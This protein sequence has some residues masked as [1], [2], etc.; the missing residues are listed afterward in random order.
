[1][2][3]PNSW[4]SLENR[5][6]R[7]QLQYSSGPS[8][9]SCHLASCIYAV[10]P[11]AGPIALIPD[12]GWGITHSLTIHT[13]S[14]EKLHHIERLRERVKL[15]DPPFRAVA[16]G[17][18]A[19]DLLTI[20]YNDGL[21]IRLPG[22]GDL[23]HVRS[24]RVF[25]RDSVYD[26]TVLHTGDVVIRTDSGTV[27]RVDAFEKLLTESFNIRPPERVAADILNSGISAIAPENSS[28]EVIETVLITE[29]RSV[30]VANSSGVHTIASTNVS[31]IAL[32]SNGKYV[33]A[34]ESSTGGIFVWDI[35]RQTEI[36][37]LN[38]VVELSILG[39]ENALSEE[40]FDARK[41]DSLSWVGS[42]AIAVLYKEH[43]VLVGPKR[44]IAV[45]HLGESEIT[46]GVILNNEKDGLRLISAQRIEF[47][48]MVP[49][50]ITSIFYQK[51]APSYKLFK[52]SGV[53]DGIEPIS[54]QALVRYRLLRELR[55]AGTLLEAA[56]SCVNAAYLELD[57]KVQKQLLRAAAY[58]QR[59][60]T[61]FADDKDSAMSANS[62]LPVM[63]KRRDARLR[64]DVGM[65]PTA[66]AILR[67]LNA[68]AS[69]LSGVPLT[70]TQFDSL[71]LPGLVARLSR[72]GKHTL[73]L[74]LASF[75]GISPYDVLAEWSKDV[76]RNHSNE[77]D[78]LIKYIIEDKFEA[79]SK[80][81]ANF[82]RHGSRKSRA[83]PYV[84]AAEAAFA[85]K[86]PKCAELLLRQ[87]TRP[88]PKVDMFLKMGREKQAVTSAVASGDPELVLDVLGHI[89]EVKN[90]KETAR[91]IRSLQASI[92]TRATDLLA[93][94]M[95]QIGSTAGLKILYWEVG[96]W[97]EATM[98]DIQL[99][100]LSPDP[101]KRMGDLEAVA[102]SIGKGRYRRAC[103][104]ELHAVQHAAA[105][106][107]NAIELERRAKL[108]PGSMRYANDGELLAKTIQSISDSSKREDMLARLRRELMVPERRFFWICL[109]SMADIG[110][111]KSIESLSNTAGRGK[112]PPIGFSAFVDV[113]LKHGKEEQAVKSARR[114]VDLRDRAR[115]LARSGQGREAADIA[116]RL[117]NQQLL[118]E[119]QDLTARHVN[120]LPMPTRKSDGEGPKTGA[121]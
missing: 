81:F 109:N 25:E 6:Y 75:G 113:F 10:A 65:I 48:Q 93:T 60:S 101:R 56:R 92:C 117:G 36:V 96:R 119:V 94:H 21:L 85:A 120:Q 42:D 12:A 4:I 8:V 39:V 108:E 112:G 55:E 53:M 99:A 41:P 89:L 104:F 63:R 28:H 88:A 114:I 2:A 73:A 37:R 27:Y 68:S 31:H 66:I 7:R 5:F 34:L 26:A 91:I 23:T 9:S 59:Y 82:D 121:G 83:L 32:S 14:G 11:N 103:R 1:M 77:P 107:A 44:G 16:L 102:K 106:A 110:D 57:V 76:I 18:S 74:R 111:F 64:R 58:G 20:V 100:N 45:L 61:V 67:V 22:G 33:V 3:V 97:R 15:T 98:V 43:L 71:G 30:A 51:Q 62:E 52:S 70:K 95:K 105:V 47:L 80:S 54:T 78:E 118:E 35:V 17:W 49:E 38:L 69:E 90:V 46:T 13:L 115:A 84:L 72:Y 50:L 40:L 19:D 29:N 87:E 79:V 86:R 24:V 116:S